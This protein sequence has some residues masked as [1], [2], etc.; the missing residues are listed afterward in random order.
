MLPTVLWT[1]SGSK[2]LSPMACVLEPHLTVLGSVNY[3]HGA[4]ENEVC[5][6]KIDL[7]DIKL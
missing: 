5:F 2:E 1:W 7:A 3:A 6:W 4:V